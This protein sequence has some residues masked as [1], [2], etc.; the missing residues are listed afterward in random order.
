MGDT[1]IVADVLIREVA[2]DSPALEINLDERLYGAV[3]VSDVDERGLRLEDG[4]E[5]SIGSEPLGRSAR[6][7]LWEATRYG[8]E[9]GG[10]TGVVGSLRVQHW[11]AVEPGC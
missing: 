8:V 5:V 6:V 3:R 9:L 1:W 2:S 7:A 11:C 4:R 10:D